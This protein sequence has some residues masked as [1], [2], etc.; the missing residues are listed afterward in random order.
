MLSL[1]IL[2]GLA[3]LTQGFLDFLA[4]D[5]DNIQSDSE[6]LERS[7]IGDDRNVSEPEAA[8]TGKFS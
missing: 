7:E 8:D 6:L 4:Q 3:L 5:S 2:R 1:R